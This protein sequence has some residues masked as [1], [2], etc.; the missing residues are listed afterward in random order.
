MIVINMPG[1]AIQN[2][3]ESEMRGKNKVVSI[4]KY[5]NFS[6]SLLFR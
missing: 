6:K 4:R 2:I 3:D 5:I 1:G